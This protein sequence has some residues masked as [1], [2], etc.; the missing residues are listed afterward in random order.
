MILLM[1][2]NLCASA[3]RTYRQ[4]KNVQAVEAHTANTQ[5][6]VLVHTRQGMMVSTRNPVPFS[7]FVL[8]SSWYSRL[9]TY[10]SL[11]LLLMVL[12]TF[13]IQRGLSDGT[14]QNL[15]KGLSFFG[16]TQYS[17]NDIQTAAHVTRVNA[18]QQL[19][20]ISQLDPAQYSSSA[21]MEYLGLF[22][23]FD[24]CNDR[25]LR[26]LRSEFSHH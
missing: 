11:S 15:S 5:G 26:C 12:A 24:R 19:M 17:A 9:R 3:L 16:S 1:V 4:Q 13:F 2:G 21:R 14:L 20:R 6:L 10:V 7:V 18:T 22:S 8:P 25:G 23:L